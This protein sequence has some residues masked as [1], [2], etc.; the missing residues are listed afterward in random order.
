MIE[1]I[2]RSI[3]ALQGKLYRPK[4]KGPTGMDHRERGSHARGIQNMEERN[5]STKGKSPKQCL[6]SS[7]DITIV[8]A[9]LQRDV[10][11]DMLCPNVEYMS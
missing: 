8:Q 2:S 10:A 3:A 4:Y 5:V 1:L 7:K 6:T 11:G 9:I